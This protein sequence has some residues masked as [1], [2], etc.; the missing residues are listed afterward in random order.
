MNRRNV[1]REERGFTL[2]ELMI[3]VAII[4]ILAGVLIPNLLRPTSTTKEAAAVGAL[5]NI[6]TSLIQYQ[7]TYQGYPQGGTW[8]ANMYGANCA[9]ATA[10]SPDFGPPGFCRTLVGGGQA[11]TVQGYVYTY[12]GAA[13]AGAA[14][15]TYSVLAVPSSNRNGNRSFFTDESAEIHHCLGANGTMA[16][17]RN[18]PTID[19]TPVNCT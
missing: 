5:R 9:S 19:Q 13:G 18:W 3:V 11:N 1:V 12:A 10:P 4:G 17:G 2:V 8:Q 7:G 16:N 6:N 15:P 14:G